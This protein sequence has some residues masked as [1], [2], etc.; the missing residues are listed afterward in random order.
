MTI[1]WLW[2]ANRMPAASVLDIFW[3]YSGDLTR[4]NT[5]GASWDGT[6]LRLMHDYWGFF[7]AMKSRILGQEPEKKY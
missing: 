7:V 1:W 2:L 4:D 5:G 3:R 6:V